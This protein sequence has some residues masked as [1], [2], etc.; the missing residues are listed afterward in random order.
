M[1]CHQSRR[2]GR[3]SPRAASSPASHSGRPHPPGPGR[4]DPGQDPTSPS[5][6]R[7]R[8][9]AR[10]SLARRC[11]PC[12]SPWPAAS[13]AAH[14]NNHPTRLSSQQLNPASRNATTASASLH[15]RTASTSASSVKSNP[16]QST[17]TSTSAAS[18]AGRSNFLKTRAFYLYV[19]TKDRPNQKA[20]EKLFRTA[21]PNFIF[22]YTRVPF[23]PF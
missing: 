23:R 16:L 14:P 19:I 9:A 5:S 15:S 21:V 4:P 11:I 17:S 18:T 12:G 10:P 8:P 1:P 3:P 13:R 2:A 7:Q 20:T 22:G 6:R